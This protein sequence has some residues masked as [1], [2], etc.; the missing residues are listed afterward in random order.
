VGLLAAIERTLTRKS[1]LWLAS[2]SRFETLLHEALSDIA[3]GVD[4]TVEGLGHVMIG[5]VRAIG[6]DLE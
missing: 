3:Y 4:V 1:L 2:Q 6:I 5:L